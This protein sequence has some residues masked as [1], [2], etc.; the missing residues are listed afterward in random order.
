MTVYRIKISNTWGLTQSW[1]SRGG[2]KSHDLMLIQ[3]MYIRKFI[4]GTFPGVF[5]II[6]QKRGNCI[7]VTFWLKLTAYEFTL[8]S[9]SFLISYSETLLTHWLGC[10]VKIVVQGYHKLPSNKL[11]KQ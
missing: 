10:N 6:E 8:P 9:L 11:L 4:F 5:H 7:V 1:S 2:V 3:D